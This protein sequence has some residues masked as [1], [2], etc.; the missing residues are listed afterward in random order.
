[1]SLPM[2]VSARE[3]EVYAFVAAARRAVCQ[4]LVRVTVR[5]AM[6]ISAELRLPRKTPLPLVPSLTPTD[7]ENP[8][9]RVAPRR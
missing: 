3:R 1:M 8:K 6:L 5:F 9:V 2:P 7:P 4:W